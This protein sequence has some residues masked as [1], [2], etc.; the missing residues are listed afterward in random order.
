MQQQLSTVMVAGRGRLMVMVACHGRW[1]P[2]GH[3]RR[4]CRRVEFLRRVDAQLGRRMRRRHALHAVGRRVGRMMQ[5]RPAGSAVQGQGLRQLRM[6]SQ[7]NRL[8]GEL[9]RHL[10][11]VGEALQIAP[12]TEQTGGRV[13]LERR[14]AARGC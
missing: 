13:Q 4:H 11:Q 12:G 9:L 5:S 1:H 10:L 8:D 3:C 6:R 14:Q 7:D 2:A